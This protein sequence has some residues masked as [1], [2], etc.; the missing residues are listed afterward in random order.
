MNCSPSG[1]EIIKRACLRT[2]MKREHGAHRN[3]VSVQIEKHE[4]KQHD[5]L[6]DLGDFE[7]HQF[8]STQPSERWQP[9]LGFC[10]VNGHRS[11][12]RAAHFAHFAYLC[13]GSRGDT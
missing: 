12:Q 8:T 3:P 11:L 4:Q 2:R 1:I 5:G 9:L 10:P 7:R 6:N 13:E